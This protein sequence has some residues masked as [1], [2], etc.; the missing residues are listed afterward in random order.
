MADIVIRHNIIQDQPVT[1]SFVSVGPI[2]DTN[3]M[4]SGGVWLS[5]EGIT[6]AGAPIEIRMVWR[7][8]H[9][10]DNGGLEGYDF[11]LEPDGSTIKSFI[12]ASF[13]LEKFS[14]DTGVIHW[15]F[16]VNGRYSCRIQIK[17]DSPGDLNIVRGDV[18]LR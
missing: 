4:D 16:P 3:H 13:P 10:L 17:C 2:I 18:T 1:S 14:A 7:S 8:A 9:F 6:S 11:V 5:L 12:S 15:T